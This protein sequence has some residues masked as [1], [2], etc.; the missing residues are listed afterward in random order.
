MHLTMA[1]SC[2]PH[3]E[4]SSP[5]EDQGALVQGPFSLRRQM[6]PLFKTPSDSAEDVGRHGRVGKEA[7]VVNQVLISFRLFNSWVTF[8]FFNQRSVV[9]DQMEKQ[10]MLHLMEELIEYKTV[11]H[12]SPFE[13]WAYNGA[14]GSPML[15][16]EGVARPVLGAWH[17]QAWLA[18]S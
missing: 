3:H 18:G 5:S 7:W 13:H 4:A 1:A 6:G 12:G 14:C 8:L 17:S 2:N 16:R 15:L 11:E 9:Q 10:I